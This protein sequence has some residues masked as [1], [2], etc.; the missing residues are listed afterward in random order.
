MPTYYYYNRY[1]AREGLKY[2]HENRVKIDAVHVQPLDFIQEIQLGDCRH[3]T[4]AKWPSSSNRKDLHGGGARCGI[5]RTC[6]GSTTPVPRK[7]LCDT[8]AH[9]I[10]T[11]R[12]YGCF[13]FFS[14]LTSVLC[15]FL[16]SGSPAPRSDWKR[17][18][19]R[20][21]SRPCVVCGRNLQ[22]RLEKKV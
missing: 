13:F 18:G 12:Y 8:G 20:T 9:I 21:R 11:L 4:P 3:L 7:R 2:T 1:Y 10:V 19:I 5:R 6:A 22:V 16:R 15:V 14:L 17:I